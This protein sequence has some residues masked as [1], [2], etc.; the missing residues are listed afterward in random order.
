MNKYFVTF[1]QALALKELGFDE[2]CLAWFGSMRVLT[3]EKTFKNRSGTSTVNKKWNNCTNI[4][5]YSQAFEWFRNKG[6]KFH[7]YEDRWNHYCS[8]Y[9]NVTNI[10]EYVEVSVESTYQQAES[11]CLDELIKTIKS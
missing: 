6:Y 8:V 7:I 9:V 4:P 5:L 2:P 1:E 11:A 3:L 10:T